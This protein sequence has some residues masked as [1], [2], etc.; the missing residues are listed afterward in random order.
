M[1]PD[2]VSDDGRV[3]LYCAD[4]LDVLPTLAAGSVDAVITDPPYPN[5]HADKYGYRE[6]GIDFLN[7]FPC[8]QFVFWTVTEDFPLTYSAKHIWDKITGTYARYENIYER[9]GGAYG[10][11]FRY[12]K[13]NNFI[14]AQFY[15]D[16]FTGHPSQK[17]LSL[18]KKLVSRFTVADM[19][20]FDFFM[21]SGTT[22]VAAINLGRRFIGVEIERKYFDIAVKRISDALAQPAL[23]QV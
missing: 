14:D 2:F 19:A 6:G 4:C 22:G 9:N 13:Y 21:G 3:T 1:Q 12:Q 20:I 18:I 16:V 5:F 11:T 17:N 15:R 10:M 7:I 23:F 8:R